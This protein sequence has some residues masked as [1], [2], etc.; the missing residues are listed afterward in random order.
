[1][2][3]QEKYHLVITWPMQ[4]GTVIEYAKRN[5][6]TTIDTK[7]FAWEIKMLAAN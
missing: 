7:N 4:K 3:T 1:M 2:K 5:P 6:T